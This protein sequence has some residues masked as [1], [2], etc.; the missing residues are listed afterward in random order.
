MSSLEIGFTVNIVADKISKKI[1]KQNEIIYLLEEDSIFSIILGNQTFNHCQAIIYYN[2]EKIGVFKID[3]ISTTTVNRS[4]YVNKKLKFV[5]EENRKNGLLEIYFMPEKMI[6]TEIV[7][8]INS[9]NK[10][11]ISRKNNFTDKNQKISIK[12]LNYNKR[13]NNEITK[14]HKFEKIINERQYED[15]YIMNKI[16]PY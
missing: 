5:K 9:C 11:I 3:P 13:N 15:F 6:Q 4:L 8:K 16:M 14:Q 2:K 1:V 12:L 7:Q 10:N